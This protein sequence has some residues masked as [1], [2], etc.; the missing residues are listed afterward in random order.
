MKK[1]CFITVGTDEEYDLENNIVRY[2]D[3]STIQQDFLDDST[4]NQTVLI[5]LS[6]FHGFHD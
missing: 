4:G 3:N 1:P 6:S 5:Y 2:L